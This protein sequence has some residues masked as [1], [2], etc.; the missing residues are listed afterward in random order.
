MLPPFLFLK[1]DKTMTTDSI[2]K[3][4]SFR[5]KVLT[6]TYTTMTISEDLPEYLRK[7]RRVTSSREVYQMFKHLMTNPREVFLCLHLNSKNTIVCVDPVSQGSLNASIVHPREVFSSALLSAAAALVFI[8]QHPSGDPEPS[9]EDIE[10]TTR[11]QD[12]AKL[13]GIRVLDH[14]IIGED[15]YISFADRGMLS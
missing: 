14:I 8:H 13:L 1:G 2:N 11:L 10:L 4:K 5:L 9:R 15:R 6:P 3:H 12:G 7:T